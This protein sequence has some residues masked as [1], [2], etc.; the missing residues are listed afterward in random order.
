[1]TPL[2]LFIIEGLGR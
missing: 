2:K 1:M